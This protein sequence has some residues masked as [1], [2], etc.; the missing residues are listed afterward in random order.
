MKF[1]VGDKVKVREDLIADT[2]YND[3]FFE[4]EMKKYGGEE[5]T[6]EIVFEDY[7]LLDGC[8]EWQFT[9]EM[10]LPVET[11]TKFEE[12]ITPQSF[13]SNDGRFTIKVEDDGFLELTTTSL[14]SD[15]KGYLNDDMDWVQNLSINANDLQRVIDILER[16]KEINCYSLSSWQEKMENKV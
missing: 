6:I 4:Y 11:P 12:Q 14:R 15:E 5:Y 7:Y 3:I 8:D 1:K 9:D 13:E 10:L 16:A 2:Y